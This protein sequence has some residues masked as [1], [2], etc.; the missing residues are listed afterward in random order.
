MS[1]RRHKLGIS[2]HQ[3]KTTLPG[4]VYILSHWPKG[5]HG[6]PQT[7]QTIAKTICYFHNIMAGP[8][9]EDNTYVTKHG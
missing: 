2:C 5:F 6:K 3:V 4:M 8:I 1:K 7:S 9:A